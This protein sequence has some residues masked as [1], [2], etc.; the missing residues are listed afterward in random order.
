MKYVPGYLD[1]FI[2]PYS[3]KLIGNNIIPLQEDYILI[4]DV[5]GYSIA[6]PAL[7]DVRLDIIALRGLLSTAKLLLQQAK[8]GLDSAQDL[9]LVPNGM[10]SIN[11]GTILQTHLTHN[12]FWIGDVN[13]LVTET[14]TLPSGGLPDLT[15]QYFWLGDGSERPV[16]TLF[17]I[18][19]GTGL[20][21]GPIIGNGTI[22]IAN[23]GIGPGVY[24]YATVNVN[25]QGQI[26]A[27][28]S[29]STTINSILT[30]LSD[31]ANIVNALS[32]AVDALSSAVNAIE[33]GI[34]GIGGFAA[35]LLLQGQVLGLIGAVA[36]HSS[37]IDNIDNTISIIVGQLG[38]ISGR[39]DVVE[40]RLDN[41]RLNEILADADVSFYGFKL[42][43]LADPTSPQDGATKNYVDNEIADIPGSLII[44]LGGAVS[45]TGPSNTTIDTTFHWTLNQIAATNPTSGSVA[46]NDHR[47][48]GLG[49]PTFEQDGVN[50][51]TLDDSI[52]NLDI[53]LEGFVIGGPAVD[54][55][56]ETFRGPTCLLTNIPAGGDVSMDG[57]RIEDLHQS[58]EGVFDAISAQFLWDLMHD[59][60][61]VTW[62]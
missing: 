34:S 5:T 52:A 27:A 61:T 39:I 33:S 14:D 26:L 17:N 41:L 46:L 13:D 60:V 35:I 2:S 22:S 36:T 37:Q 43:D 62:L 3:G 15:E 53:T 23:T 11:N 7:I 18:V 59:E 29:N 16:E 6:S 38:I 10:I 32:S 40:S 42:I 20:T 25:A 49:D 44:T 30:N 58:P 1:S 55:V 19:T 48:I 56:L 45:G 28:H 21:G 51:R 54:G 4:G 50:L 12:K 31:L 47:I 24:D 57:Y 9:S 8:D